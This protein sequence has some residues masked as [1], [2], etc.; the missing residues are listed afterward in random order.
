MTEIWEILR[1]LIE[2]VLGGAIV[3][4]ATLAASKRK[5]K[6]EAGHAEMDLAKDYVDQFRDNVVVPLQ[7]D[8]KGLRREVKGLKNA[9]SKINSCPHSAECPVRDELQKQ[10]RDNQGDE[11]GR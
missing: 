6:A 4:V 2:L 9:V 1:S 10:Q 8:V 3:T 5:A 7:K 11:E